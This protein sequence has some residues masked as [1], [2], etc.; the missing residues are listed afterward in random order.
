MEL[1]LARFEEARGTRTPTRERLSA[2]LSATTSSTPCP[3]SSSSRRQGSRP[4]SSV[5]ASD[6]TLRR[7]KR[8]S[9]VRMEACRCPAPSHAPSSVSKTRH[10]GFSVP[11]PYSEWRVTNS[12]STPYAHAPRWLAATLNNSKDC[13]RDRPL[14]LGFTAPRRVTT[15]L[16]TL[17]ALG[18]TEAVE[19]AASKLMLPELT[20]SPFALR[21]LGRIQTDASLLLQAADGSRRSA[22]TGT[23]HKH[24]RRNQIES[25]RPLSPFGPVS[26]RQARPATRRPRLTATIRMSVFPSSRSL[27]PVNQSDRFVAKS[28]A[29]SPSTVCCSIL[30]VTVPPFPGRGRRGDPNES[31]S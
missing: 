16:E 15:R 18:R 31:S 19:E 1:G 27:R 11:R 30:N 20:S 23:P 28:P 4:P 5:A 7:G 14:A 10:S 26:T 9:C 25:T 3:P 24:S 6:R 29:G 2:P 22:S 12:S 8:R 21:A 13:P 17:V